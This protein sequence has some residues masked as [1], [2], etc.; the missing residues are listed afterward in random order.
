MKSLELLAIGV[1]LM[2]IYT[3]IYA[4]RSAINVNRLLEQF[5]YQIHQDPTFGLAMMVGEVVL[6][7]VAAIIMLRFPL[8][9]SRWLLPKTKE[10]EMVLKGEPQDIEWVLYSVLGIYILASALP[11]LV[12]NG[13]SWWYIG[14]ASEYAQSYKERYIVYEVATVVEIGIGLYLCLRAEGLMR[15]LKR[16]RHAGVN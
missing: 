14:H 3:I 13:L 7:V 8:T 10:G 9:I 15:L 5:N 16:L 11:D 12:Q 1:R 2:G 4:L 6:M